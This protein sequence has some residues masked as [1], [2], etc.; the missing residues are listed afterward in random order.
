MF[1]IRKVKEVFRSKI[2]DC[3]VVGVV[4]LE[5]NDDDGIEPHAALTE[6]VIHVKPGDLVQVYS[7]EFVNYKGYGAMVMQVI[8]D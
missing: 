6:D 4:V 2:N 5:A 1:E 3:F 8:S 7:D